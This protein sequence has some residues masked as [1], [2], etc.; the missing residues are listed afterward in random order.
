MK[1][2]KEKED[3]EK[4][5]SKMKYFD[6]S[7][8]DEIPVK[9]ISHGM[10]Q[11]TD[12][13]F[14]GIIEVLPIDFYKR[15]VE[16]QEY[17]LNNFQR[18]FVNGPARMSLITLSDTTN[19]EKIIKYVRKK[20]IGTND[21][22]IIFARDDYIRNIRIQAGN[23]T[24]E[25]RYLLVYEYSGNTNGTMSKKINEIS[26]AME[27]TRTSIINILRDSDNLC[28]IPDN[29]D[30][31]LCDILYYFFNRKTYRMEP[32]EARTKRF[33]SDAKMF[34]EKSS[35]KINPSFSDFIAPKGLYFLDRNYVWMDGSYYSYVA[36][37]DKSWESSGIIGS[38]IDRFDYGARVDITVPIK[39]SPRGI[40]N[41][42]IKQKNKNDKQRVWEKNA[43]NRT[44][45]AAS[46]DEKLTNNRYVQKILDQGGDIFDC[47]LILTI[48]GDSVKQLEGMLR[49][50]IKHLSQ[51]D[52]EVDTS[53]L[54]IEDYF[55]I[56][57]P[58]L[59]FPNELFTRTKR[60]LVTPTMSVL[61]NY[62]AY[63]LQDP[64]GIVIGTHGENN[65]LL[66]INN[67]NSAIYKNANILLLGTSGAGKTFTEQHLARFMRLSGIR[68]FFIIPKKGMIDYCKGCKDLSGSF[69]QLI[70][71]SKDCINPLGII[72]EGVIDESLLDDNTIVQKNSVVSKKV[73]NVMIWLQLLLNKQ[74]LSMPEYND[75]SSMIV[76]LYR[77]FGI[78]IDDN[79]SIFENKSTGQLKKMP[80]IED[81]SNILE[82]AGKYSAIVDVLK[83]IVSGPAKNLNGQ[84]NV[85]LNNQYIVFDVDEDIIG[86]NYLPSFL[87]TAFEF[88]YNS[89]KQNSN[90]NDAI[91]MDE[92]WKM[93]ATEDCAKQ[94]QNMVKLVRGYH[95]A[96]VIATQEVGDL[97][98]AK[99]DFG[100]S[101]INNSAIK[102]LLKMEKDDITAV[103][104]VINMTDQDSN[105]IEHFKRGE[106]MMFANSNS[107]EIRI[108]ASKKEI[109]TFTP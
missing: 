45:E 60:N 42:L 91:F 61:Y 12:D 74:E 1:M 34:N 102:I 80:I 11:T 99:G 25:K 79:D 53:F 10:I 3:P 48:R 15:S 109:D 66:S 77:H 33:N 13:R 86:E 78:S 43:R 39:R 14:I 28:V 73:I 8:Q 27:D 101:V 22:K 41:A 50:L 90:S 37:T 72:P 26:K 100:K 96:T 24:V 64:T 65:S 76:E 97:L 30:Y 36:L 49:K 69:I 20:C 35:T 94:V 93:M 88:V 5:K 16:V 98:R 84:T 29:W 67:F 70:P 108:N 82:K 106:G 9:N 47:S 51:K 57:M 87:Y 6:C 19:P 44:D 95:G 56:T 81:L 63:E 68:C 18:I 83:F 105:K 38:Y 17:C 62:T 104:D 21:P 40:T 92:V 85:D 58:L 71:G 7:S 2:E 89:V 52:I 4:E 31:F 107:V 55:K 103:R 54:C 23:D 75:I 32:L 59:F 46:I